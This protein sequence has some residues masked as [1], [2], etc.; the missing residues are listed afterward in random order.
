MHSVPKLS[1]QMSNSSS[2]AAPTA[3]QNYDI[4]CS[5]L[6]AENLNSTITYQ[7]I[8][9]GNNMLI[10][11]NTLSFTPARIS[12]AGTNYSC[13]VIVVSSYL[14]GN[15]AAVMS[16]RVKIQSELLLSLLTLL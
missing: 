9:S 14:A 8:K 4:V 2:G 5:V 6:G 1:I 15:I 7:W 11:S 16:H 10:N 13:S 3:G 12:D